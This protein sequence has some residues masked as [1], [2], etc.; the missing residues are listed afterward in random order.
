[1]GKED[2]LLKKFLES[3]D[4]IAMKKKYE[5]TSFK[6]NGDYCSYKNGSLK[7]TTATKFKEDY[8]N[9]VIK[10]Q[11]KHTD[12]DGNTSVECYER[13]YYEVWSKDPTMREYD[14]VVFDVDTK[15]V[16]KTTFNLFEGF[17]MQF[18]GL[19]KQDVSL[20]P[21]FEHIRSLVNYNE[22]AFNLHIAMLAQIFQEPWKLPHVTQ[23]FVGEQGIGKD[24]YANFLSM[25]V[26]EQYFLMTGNIDHMTGKFNSLLGGKVIVCINETDPKES[27][28]RQENIKHMITAKK[29]YIEKKHKDP[30]EQKNSIRYFWFS[31]RA[32]AFPVEPGARRPQVNQSSSKYIKL[33]QEEKKK[34][35]TNLIDN[36]FKNVDVQYKFYRYLTELDISKFDFQK[37]I[38]TDFHTELEAYSSPPM[39]LFLAKLIQSQ[40][41]TVKNYQSSPLFQQ[42]TNWLN[43]N[44]FKYE[45]DSKKFAF[46]M[47]LNYKLD[48]QKSNGVMVYKINK[49]ELKNILKNTWK[50]NFNQVD[51]DLNESCMF[52]D[53]KEP[54]YENGVN[55]DDKS[56]NIVTE[57]KN[58]NANLKKEIEE[59]KKK[60]EKLEKPKY[61]LDK[62]EKKKKIILEEQEEKV[63]LIL[64]SGVEFDEIDKFFEMEKSMF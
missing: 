56:V 33:S 4:Y 36:V 11:T 63:E 10:V 18:K 53:N 44:R 52:S 64:E 54:E 1:M 26:G 31:N 59:L 37:P 58:E 24:E 2:K 62:P 15:A 27:K 40:T 25:V 43:T 61:K 9:K 35:F 6:L 45:M 60:L 55:T 12:E 41:K 21:V 14:E 5:M 57:L 47:N 48:S 28:E 13:T 29:I 8:K 3:K 23:I 46:E 49:D 42:Y 39:A 30:V 50:I 20:E 19:Q 32:F 38:R 22:E 7:Q 16:P 34:H 17:G 51:A